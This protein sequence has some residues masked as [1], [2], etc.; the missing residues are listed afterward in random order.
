MIPSWGGLTLEVDHRSTLHRDPHQARPQ[1]PAPQKYV[2]IDQ[3]GAGTSDGEFM[4]RIIGSS[5]NEHDF[6]PKE[7]IGGCYGCL[8]QVVFDDASIPKFARDLPAATTSC[9][10]PM[11]TASNTPACRGAP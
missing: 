3:L 2:P 6:H 11:A 7:C 9:S 1:Q 8:F 4:T 10:R 5:K